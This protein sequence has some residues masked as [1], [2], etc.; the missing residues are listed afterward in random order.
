MRDFLCKQRELILY[1]IFGFCTFL[2]DSG[3]FFLLSW[4]FDLQNHVGLLHLCSIASTMLAIVFAYV[5]NRIFVFQSSTTGFA[6]IFCEMVSFFAARFFTTILAEILLEITVIHLGF[7]DWIM[8]IWV[9]LL[10]IVLNFLF[11]KLWI[12][13]EKEEEEKKI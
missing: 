4:V 12:F 6:K 8:K 11:S 2:V 1:S 7:T 5:T 9:N 3:G 13:N 10:V